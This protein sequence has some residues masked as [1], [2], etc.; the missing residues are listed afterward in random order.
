MAQV[1][2]NFVFVGKS[3]SVI[4]WGRALTSE[5]LS[6]LRIKRGS[7]ISVGN[8][9]SFPLPNENGDFVYT[10]VSEAAATDYVA[11]CNTFTPPPVSA[12][13]QDIPA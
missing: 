10:W 13:V 4:N 6:S 7:M 12:V 8:F 9:G 1:N 2:T 3:Q 5:E 11:Y